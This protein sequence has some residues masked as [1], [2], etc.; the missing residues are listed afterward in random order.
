MKRFFSI[1]KAAVW[2]IVVVWCWLPIFW[3]LFI[4][5]SSL[6]QAQPNQPQM[7]MPPQPNAGL[8]VKLMSSV[9]MISLFLYACWCAAGVV[10]GFGFEQTLTAMANLLGDSLR[11]KKADRD[12]DDE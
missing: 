6:G 7:Q 8:M 1:A 4:T 2:I 5:L 9:V 12:D 3:W 10:C 11:R